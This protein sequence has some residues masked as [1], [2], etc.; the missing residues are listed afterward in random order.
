MLTSD[1]ATERLCGPEF[2]MIFNVS[3]NSVTQ[4]TICRDDHR[5][6]MTEMILLA[7]MFE[8]QYNKQVSMA[9]S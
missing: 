6:V 2:M 3:S 1:N 8:Y 4:E 7:A 5:M 9:L